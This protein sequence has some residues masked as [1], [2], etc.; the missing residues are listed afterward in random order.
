MADNDEMEIDDVDETS[1]SQLATGTMVELTGLSKAKHLNGEIGEIVCYFEDKD[2][3]Q[4]KIEDGN[5][6]RVRATN[7]KVCENQSL[8]KASWRN[9]NL[10]KKNQKLLRTMYK[11]KQDAEQRRAMYM[12]GGLFVC[13]ILFM[14]IQTGALR[15]IYQDS[16]AAPY[17]QKVGDPIYANVLVP[18]YEK[19]LVPA[20]ENVL[21]PFNKHIIQPI[22]GV[23]KQISN[24]LAEYVLRPFQKKVLQPGYEAIKPVITASQDAWNSVKDALK[25]VLEP[26][27]GSGEDSSGVTNMEDTVGE[28]ASTPFVEEIEHTEHEEL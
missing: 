22:L 28:A 4:V 18:T 26:L 1:V 27:F 24:A 11:M 3:Y 10:A 7:I 2:R 13:L 8:T 25:S 21:V 14:L 19:L 16:F 15:Y 12:I 9:K 23:L 20:Y 17:L 5:H 6:K